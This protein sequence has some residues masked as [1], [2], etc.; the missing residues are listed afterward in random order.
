MIWFFDLDNT[1]H[2]ASHEIFEKISE[3][4]NAYIEK[5]LLDSGEESNAARASALRME[6]WQRYGVTLL[7]LVRHHGVDA[8]EFLAAAH[9]FAH[10]PSMI[11]AEK[12]LRHLFRRLPGRK[13]L[14]TNA[15]RAYSREVVRHLGLH[16]HICKHIPIESMRVN[17]SLRPKPSR[18]LMRNLVAKERKRA[19][20]CVLVEDSL[21]NL[22]S[23]KYL[24]M[25]TVFVQQY[26]G[27]RA[28]RSAYVDLNVKSVRQLPA[29]LAKLR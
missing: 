12:G 9:D 18:H 17:G 24:N 26:A 28:R 23:A 19:K 7:G 21:E 25:R 8:D 27:R 6:Y 4:M 14:L 15:P 2:H 22:K 29:K 11:R 20:R 5:M 13:I 16:R 3:N 10:L 1:L